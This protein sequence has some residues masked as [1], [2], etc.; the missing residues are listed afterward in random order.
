MRKSQ[1]SAAFWRASVGSNRLSQKIRELGS[2][3]PEW[4]VLAVTMASQ[5]GLSDSDL[6]WLRA[7]AALGETKAREV[8]SEMGSNPEPES[9]LASRILKFVV[10][11]TPDAEL[12]EAYRQARSWVE[13]IR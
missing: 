2:R 6:V 3:S 4:E 13:P 9:P 1:L 12:D 11:G 8:L 5:L 7:N 10:E